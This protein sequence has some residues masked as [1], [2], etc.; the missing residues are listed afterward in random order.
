[1]Y[2]IIDL[3]S[4]SGP[5]L[6]WVRLT[7]VTCTSCLQIVLG[8]TLLLSLTRIFLVAQFHNQ[9]MWDHL[10]SDEHEVRLTYG[11]HV[12]EMCVCFFF[13][14]LLNTEAEIDLSL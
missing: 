13:E 7:G 11:S 6:A 2:R 14:D 12:K 4:K 8:H 5:S 3:E 9:I 10:A 1:M